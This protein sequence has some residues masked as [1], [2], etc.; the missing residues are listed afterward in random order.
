[1][2]DLENEIEDSKAIFIS[3][4]QGRP[5]D[6]PTLVAKLNEHGNTGEANDS[7][8]RWVIPPQTGLGLRTGLLTISCS[9]HDHQC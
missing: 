7:E 9:R 4:S 8:A 5:Y 3:R 6:V 2:N 1:M